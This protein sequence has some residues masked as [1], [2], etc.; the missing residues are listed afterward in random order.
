MTDYGVPSGGYE[1]PPPPARAMVVKRISEDQPYL[2]RPSLRKRAV[3]V[4]LLLLF[5]L[6]VLACPVGAAISS[7]GDAADAVAIVLCVE[8][9]V[10]GAVGSQLYLISSGGPM[11][12]VN[13]HGVWIK[14]RPTR[15]QAVFLPWPAIERIYRRR[16]AFDKM[17]CVQPRDPRSAQGLGAF[18]AVDASMQKLF[19]GTGFTAALTYADRPE[20]EVFAAIA[21]YAAG[22][23]R[24]DAPPG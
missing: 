12:A 6:L 8:L 4:G 20:R 21:Y 19:F 16:W 3:Q 22:R 23:V 14:T 24:I 11:L 9:V 13:P 18:T 10:V 15:G 17:L 2:V 5:V 7:G 1:P